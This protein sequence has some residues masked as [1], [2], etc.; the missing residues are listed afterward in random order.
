M[1]ATLS[2]HWRYHVRLTF[3]QGVLHQTY[4]NNDVEY[5]QIILPISYQVQVLQMLHDGQGHQGV[6]QTIALCRE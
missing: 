3:K 1:A 4:I 5:H 2:V 6:D